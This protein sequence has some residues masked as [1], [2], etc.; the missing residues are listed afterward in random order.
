MIEGRAPCLPG[1]SCAPPEWAGTIAG[2]PLVGQLR[3]CFQLVD[4]LI[5]KPPE[6]GCPGRLTQFS[7]DYLVLTYVSIPFIGDSRLGGGSP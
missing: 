2:S 5:V 1:R 6:F 7:S 3:G 4:Q